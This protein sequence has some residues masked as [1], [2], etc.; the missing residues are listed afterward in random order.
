MY[1]SKRFN[2]ADMTLMVLLGFKSLFRPGEQLFSC[3]CIY[4]NLHAHVFSCSMMPCSCV[5]HL[6]LH[7][8]IIKE[9]LAGMGCCDIP[10][11]FLTNTTVLLKLTSH[12]S[13][14]VLIVELPPIRWASIIKTPII[15]VL[16]LSLQSLL[17]CII[18]AELKTS[19][20]P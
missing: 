15:R 3:S 14:R 13:R 12:S 18:R 19:K 6:S 16:E 8:F 20:H 4:V 9:L 17:R 2:F 1:Y 10:L 11:P 5:N 7:N